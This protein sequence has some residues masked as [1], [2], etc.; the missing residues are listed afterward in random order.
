MLKPVVQGQQA[1]SCGNDPQ[2][3][4]KPDSPLNLSVSFVLLLLAEIP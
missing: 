4:G 1:C 3:L 2:L